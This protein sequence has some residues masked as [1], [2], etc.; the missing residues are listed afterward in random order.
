MT[1]RLMLICQGA[2]RATRRS[3]FPANEPLEERA[4]SAAAAVR[5]GWRA[6]RGWVSPMQA[7]RQTAEI[8]SLGCREDPRLRDLDHGEWAGRTLADIAQEQ[9]D[10]LA[11][12]LGD[13]Q[14]DGHGGESI[15]MLLERSGSWLDAQAME[16]G[17]T[18]AVTH[19]A[20]VK[21]MI[22]HVL[23]APPEAFWRIDIAPLSLTDLRHDGRRWTIRSCG[24]AMA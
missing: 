8:M 2:T 18:V 10:R 16:R 17:R 23:S 6:E 14:F 9:P 24:A 19:A 11:R 5:L 3:A 13:P 20:V 21:A 7:A 22:V 12:W 1:S 15:A 4:R